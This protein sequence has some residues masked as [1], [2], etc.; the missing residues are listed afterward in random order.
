[1]H[2]PADAPAAPDDGPKWN[3][4]DLSAEAKDKKE[5]TLKAFRDRVAQLAAQ[6]SQPACA[7]KHSALLQAPVHTRPRQPALHP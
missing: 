6:V 4:L 2:P 1:M 7:S 3:Q 5:A